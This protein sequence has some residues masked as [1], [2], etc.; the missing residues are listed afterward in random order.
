MRINVSVRMYNVL[1]P[2][3][4]TEPFVFGNGTKEK[5]A[6]ILLIKIV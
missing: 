3:N 1:E 6:I 2:K 5:I 4:I